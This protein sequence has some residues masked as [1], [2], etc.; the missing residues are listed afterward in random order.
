MSSRLL[1]WSAPLL[2]VAL[3]AVGVLGASR[4]EPVP[5]DADGAPG[6]EILRSATPLAVR[7]V[8]PAA[9]DHLR[10]PARPV[11]VLAVAA[12]AALVALRSRPA[13]LVPV[14][15]PATGRIGASPLRRRG[16][17]RRAR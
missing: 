13:P 2:V 11:A 10:A 8:R 1:R 6:A 3:A 16:P 15:V 7:A 17:P 4:A 9:G 5:A 12:A 14:P